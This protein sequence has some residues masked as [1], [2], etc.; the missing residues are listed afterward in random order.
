MNQDSYYSK[1]LSAERLKLCYEIAPPRVKRYL[2][3]EIDHVL[4]KISTDDIV[5]ELGCGYGRVLKQLAKKAHTVVGIDTSYD[6]LL[7]AKRELMNK[8]VPYLALMN[9]IELGFFQSCFNVVLCIQN[10][11]SAFHVDPYKLITS[12]LHVTKPGGLSIFSSYSEQFWE[13]RL[14]WFEIQSSFGLIGEIDYKKTQNGKIVCKDG[15]KAK[16][17]NIHQFK[18][19]ITK[20][21]VKADIYTVDD[22]SIFCEITASS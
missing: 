1:I 17:F 4:D 21:G 18:S 6:S 19:L 5:L 7:V 13:D 10:G 3:S 20:I 16:T 12:A 9:A 14:K 15:F 2:Q 11:I 22:S 8:S